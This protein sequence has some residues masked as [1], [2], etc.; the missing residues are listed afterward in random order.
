MRHFD[1]DREIRPVPPSRTPSRQLPSPAPDLDSLS[2]LDPLDIDARLDELREL[3]DG[4]LDGQGYAPVGTGLTWLAASFNRYYPESLL[5][6]RLYPT[7]DGGIQAEWMIAA[8]DIDI[9]INLVSKSGEWHSLDLASDT[10][11]QKTLNLDDED[12]WKWI[13]KK[14]QTLSEKSK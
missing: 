9:K 13:V 14:I 3:N 7:V 2:L 8:T 5:R 12:A 11:H 10:E 4:W 1:L 6:P